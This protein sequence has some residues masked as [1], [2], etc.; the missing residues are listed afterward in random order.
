M[1]AKEGVQTGV[2]PFES[3]T[4]VGGNKVLIGEGFLPVGLLG[5]E[6]EVANLCRLF[7]DRKK[8]RAAIVMTRK[9]RLSCALDFGVSV[10]ALPHLKPSATAWPGGGGIGHPRW[11][12][13]RAGAAV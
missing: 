4:W 11:N 2:D 5:E 10:S 9:R 12:E 13:R 8:G 3:G 1:K 7:L 6:D